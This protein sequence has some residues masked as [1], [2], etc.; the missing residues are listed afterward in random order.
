MKIILPDSKEIK[1]YRGEGG[2]QVSSVSLP[3]GK[4]VEKMAFLEVVI[5]AGSKASEHYHENFTEVFYLL[6]PMRA[7]FNGQE[8]NLP[9]G[10]LVVLDPG[11]RHEEYAD[12]EN[13]CYL[14]FKLPEVENDKILT[15]K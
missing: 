2:Y 8:Y 12:K 5:P 9:S 11:D 13:I 15:G 10:S 4:M 1:R 6:T 14:V 7:K 3:I